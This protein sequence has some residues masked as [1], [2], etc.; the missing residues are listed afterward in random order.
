M[1]ITL[2]EKQRLVC[3]VLHENKLVIYIS[4]AIV[5]EKEA[6][7]CESQDYSVSQQ[8]FIRHILDAKDGAISQQCKDR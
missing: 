4:R 1:P 8:T 2:D 5:P 7:W 6:V 3:F